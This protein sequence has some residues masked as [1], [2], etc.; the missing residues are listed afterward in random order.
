MSTA[1]GPASSQ[2]VP[3]APEPDDFAIDISGLTKTFP[4]RGGRVEALQNLDVRVRLGGVTGL[5]GPDGAG[6]TTLM[7]LIAGLL[8]PDTGQITSRRRVRAMIARAGQVA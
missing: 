1:A 5:G 4:M 8:S 7:R 3:D 6:K 2:A